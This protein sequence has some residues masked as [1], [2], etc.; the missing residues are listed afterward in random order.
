M[1]TFEIPVVEITQFAVVDVI[2]TSV[3]EPT[4]FVPPE[5]GENQTPYG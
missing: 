5:Q 1:K 2:T 3:T 4:E